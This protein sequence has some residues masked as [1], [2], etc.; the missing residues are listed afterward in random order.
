MFEGINEN[1]RGYIIK[2]PSLSA[3]ELSLTD[4]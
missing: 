1:D 2:F 4:T 3:G